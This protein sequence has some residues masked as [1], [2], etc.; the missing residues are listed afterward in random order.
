MA[1]GIHFFFLLPPGSASAE[2]ECP[3][4]YLLVPL[5]A[6]KKGERRAVSSCVHVTRSDRQNLGMGSL[7]LAPCSNTTHSSHCLRDRTDPIKV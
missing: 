2:G 7:L 1:P 5:R 6:I 4:C 3:S